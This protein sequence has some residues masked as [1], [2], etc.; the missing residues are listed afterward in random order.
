VL[1]AKITLEGLRLRG[2]ARAA[3]HRHRGRQGHQYYL[4]VYRLT[5]RGRQAIDPCSPLRLL[6]TVRRA[7]GIP[8]RLPPIPYPRSGKKRL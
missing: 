1:W 4:S 3:C 2:L 6:Q 7:F 8:D 5:E